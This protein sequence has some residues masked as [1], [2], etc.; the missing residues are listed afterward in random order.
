MTKQR[1]ERFY[2]LRQEVSTLERR[3]EDILG[4]NEHV[5]DVVHGSSASFPYIKRN[6]AIEGSGES[7]VKRRLKQ[8]LREKKAS[9]MAELDAIME[10]IDSLEDSVVHQI[11]TLR[12][13]EGMSVEEDAGYVGYSDRQIRRII[14]ASIAS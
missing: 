14:K 1:L 10:Y 7:L 3:V 2:K 5:T 8:Q 6:I 13:V 4:D 12:Y 9:L 11:M